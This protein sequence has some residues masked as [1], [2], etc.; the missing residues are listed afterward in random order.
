MARS[1]PSNATP[2]LL[3]WARKTSG[4]PAAIAAESAKCSA[5][6]LV[7]WES[8]KGTPSLA[9][10]KKLAAR[11][12]YPLMVFYLPEPPKFAVKKLKDFRL[13]SLASEAEFSPELLYALRVAE[14]RQAWA[15]GYLEESG[16]QKCALVGI[17]TAGGEA[18]TLAAKLRIDLG[19]TIEQQTSMK[20]A[21]EAYRLWRSH[22]E[23][24]GV[25]V[26]HASG[27]P[28]EEM[29]G[30][31]I[32]DQYAPV[33]LVNGKDAYTAKIFTLI[34]ELA[35]I[36][37][38]SGAITGGGTA[39]LVPDPTVN[40]ER[41]C[42]KVAAALLLPE[43]EFAAFFP[44]HWDTDPLRAIGN[45]AR[46]FN[47]SRAVVALRIVDVGLADRSFLDGLW[48]VL[49]AKPMTGGAKTE[50][51]AKAISRAGQSFA[52]LAVSAYHSGEIHGGQLSRM[53]KMS[54]KHLPNLESYLYPNRLTA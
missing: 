39:D 6:Q 24:Q 51:Y 9:R 27:V 15:A 2:A 43:Q 3:K 22:C 11:Y 54:L 50:Q 47:V 29:R 53:L 36:A 40:V 1:L 46:H 19:V 30:C 21:A 10:L 41:F 38:G 44:S 26:F 8:G 18:A 14:D 4:V 23:D 31:A 25:F 5:D 42:N 7:D 13:L 49:Q 20:D 32:P 17:A 16:F 45:A 28:V 34:H 37:I 33:I 52:R 35:H 48:P 12:R